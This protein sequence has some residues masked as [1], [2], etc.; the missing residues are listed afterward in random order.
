MAVGL[1]LRAAKLTERAPG[2]LQD[3]AR[4]SID[5]LVGE[6]DVVVLA[7]GMS[8]VPYVRARLAAMFGPRTEIVHA[9]PAADDRSLVRSPE[10]AIAV[11]LAQAT[12]VA[13]HQEKMEGKLFVTADYLIGSR[14][15]IMKKPLGDA[16]TI[17]HAFSGRGWTSPSHIL[18][19]APFRPA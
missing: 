19:V 11:G 16:D 13:Y 1:A 6:V 14:A 18:C 3:V 8:H 4:A 15:Y 5:S 2:S 17:G 9:Y 10:L 7:G 12:P